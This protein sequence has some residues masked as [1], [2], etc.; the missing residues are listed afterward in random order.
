MKQK[1]G[2]DK[3]PAEQVVKEIRRQTRRQY[4]A[5]EKIRRLS[6]LIRFNVGG[7]Y[8]AGG[9]LC[10]GAEFFKLTTQRFWDCPIPKSD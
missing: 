2:P 7:H 1:S 6:L 5:E 10:P 8:G 4:S 9:P 3:M